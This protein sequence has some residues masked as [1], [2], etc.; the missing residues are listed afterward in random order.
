MDGKGLSVFTGYWWS[1]EPAWMLWMPFQLPRD[2]SLGCR[3]PSF[4]TQITE[5]EDLILL[6]A[7]TLWISITKKSKTQLTVVPWDQFIITC[8]LLFAVNQISLKT[9]W[10][11]F[12][13][14]QRAQWKQ[15]PE[16]I[17]PVPNH[18]R[19]I[20][21]QAS[22]EVSWSPD[23]SSALFVIK[24]NFWTCFNGARAAFSPGFYLWVVFKLGV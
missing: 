11:L 13:E 2:P 8:W 17:P 14:P 6:T 5:D 3:S 21:N 23:L 16:L 9:E 15:Q 20:L 18:T 22:P 10:I 19:Q 24:G 1:P 4:Q 12:H 7:M